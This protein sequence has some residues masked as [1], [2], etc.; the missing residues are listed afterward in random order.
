MGKKLNKKILVVDDKSE[1]RKLIKI[2]LEM[3]GYIIKEADSGQRAIELFDV[4]KPDVV[5]MDVMMA[6]RYDGY[7][8][9]ELI[10]KKQPKTKVIILTARAQRADKDI[11]KQVGSD[12]FLTKPF[13]PLHL[14]DT[15]NKLFE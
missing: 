14:L 15:V 2:T 1:L 10:K 11:A 4:V 8:A 6:G 12:L 13:S 5:I 9:C 7:Q 3:N